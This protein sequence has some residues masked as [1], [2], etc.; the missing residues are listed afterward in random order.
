MISSWSY[1]DL[2]NRCI[3]CIW[4]VKIYIRMVRMNW[5]LCRE[6]TAGVLGQSNGLAFQ[7]RSTLPHSH[8]WIHTGLVLVLRNTI[9]RHL[10]LDLL[11]W[12]TGCVSS[13]EN[14]VYWPLFVACV[15]G[16]KLCGKDLPGSK[17]GFYDVFRGIS[18]GFESHLLFNRV[19]AMLKSICDFLVATPWGTS[20][21]GYGGTGVLPPGLG[22]PRPTLTNPRPQ[23]PA[24]P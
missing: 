17:T 15:H 18:S 4:S 21:R 5:I 10:T 9:V 2:E 3:F 12:R 13:S 16:S 6:L 8:Y 22:M 1:T 24:P 23:P 20:V 19:C 14:D 7:R 11:P